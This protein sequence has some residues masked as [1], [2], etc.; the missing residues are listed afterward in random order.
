VRVRSV[1][2]KAR[3]AGERG[4][5]KRSVE[6]IVVGAEGVAGDYNKYRTEK[7]KGDPDHAVL[8]MP[9][10]MLEELAREGWPIAP[11]D[12]G[13]N[14]TTEGIAYDAMA[15]GV[16]MQ[17]GSA[18][19]EITEPCVPCSNLEVLPYIGRAKIKDFMRALLGRRGWYARVVA[20]GVVRARDPV[21]I[22]S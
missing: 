7:K 21:T 20:G 19:V 17:L 11:G 4:I 12:L 13:E 22:G 14:I 1:Q 10:E 5:P 9:H 8:I 16:Q 6:E 2:V 15:P 3:V 18:T